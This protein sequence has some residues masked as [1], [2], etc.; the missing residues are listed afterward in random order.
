VW[1]NSSAIIHGVRGDRRQELRP[2]T[3]NW[4]A[5]LVWD[6]ELQVGFPCRLEVSGFATDQQKVEIWRRDH[7]P[8]TAGLLRDPRCQESLRS[9]LNHADDT[10]DALSK[11]TKRLAAE[12]LSPG[13]F[14]KADPKRVKQLVS[15]LGSEMQYWSSLSTPF[16]GFLE[17]LGRS[18]GIT[19]EEARDHAGNVGFDAWKGSV[20]SAALDAFTRTSSGVAQSVRGLRARAIADDQ[21][22]RG[23]A[24]VARRLMG[25]GE[26]TRE[27]QMR[28]S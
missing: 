16:Y 12:I 18:Q 25:D 1:R 28:C 13:D 6:G 14:R 21:L 15:S 20:R 23:L 19:D 7:L 4:I 9:S 11:A 10:A 26:A 22:R 8:V 27:N 5:Q 2:L 24:R 17:C 3:L